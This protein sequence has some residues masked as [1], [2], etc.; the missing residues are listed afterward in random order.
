MAAG[1][2]SICFD[3]IPH[4]DI[5]VDSNM[6]VVC[7]EACSKSLSIVIDEL[8]RDEA[9]RLKIRNNTSKIKERLDIKSIGSQYLKFMKLDKC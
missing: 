9:Y 5:F 7:K 8:I 1:L 3:T 4:E 2:P 6:G